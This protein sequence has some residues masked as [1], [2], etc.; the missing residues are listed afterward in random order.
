MQLASWNGLKSWLMIVV[1]L[2]T[3]PLLAVAAH[4]SSGEVSAEG[5]VA[6][7]EPAE[8]APPAQ[9]SPA[10]PA[11]PP[12]PREEPGWTRH[13]VVVRLGEPHLRLASE[14]EAR[15]SVTVHNAGD[16]REAVDL[17]VHEARG[18]AARFSGPTWRS[19]APGEAFETTLVVGSLRWNEPGWHV[20]TVAA[21]SGQAT[22][23]ASMR[24]EVEGRPAPWPEPVAIAPVPAPAI[25]PCVLRVGCCP[26]PMLVPF[27]DVPGLPTPFAPCPPPPCPPAPVVW[28]ADQEVL[29]HLL[30]RGSVVDGKLV[31]DLDPAL[32]SR[33]RPQPEPIV[34]EAHAASEA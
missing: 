25:D 28:T 34:V 32:L 29:L 31:I 16:V 11:D 17:S 19:L 4:Q 3:V 30:L 18:V 7:G 23:Y 1:A 9:P 26:R 22:G 6:Y 13:G 33:L 2:S 8:P 5:E 24:V 12:A 27:G 14:G 20:V 21:K 15:V 10:R